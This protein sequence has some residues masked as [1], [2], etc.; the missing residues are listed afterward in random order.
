MSHVFTPLYTL[1]CA[2]DSSSTTSVAFAL[3]DSLLIS[4]DSGGRIHVWSLATR[5]ILR[6]YPPLDDADA[7]NQIRLL[8]DTT[9]A[10]TFAVFY[11]SGAI[12][13][14]DASGVVASLLTRSVS[15][16]RP[17]VLVTA[18]G[19]AVCAVPADSASDVLIV[20]L[21]PRLEYVQTVRVVIPLSA[22]TSPLLLTPR[23]TYSQQG[24]GAESTLLAIPNTSG[25]VSASAVPSESVGAVM[26]TRLLCVSASRLTALLACTESGHIAVITFASADAAPYYRAHRKMSALP[27]LTVDVSA[28]DAHNSAAQIIGVCGGADALIHVFRLLCASDVVSVIALRSVRLASAGVNTVA[29]R[30]DAAVFAVSAWDHTVTLI[31]TA[32]AQPLTV[33]AH[34]AASNESAFALTSAASTTALQVPRSVQVHSL[35]LTAA[36]TSRTAQKLP[37]FDVA[38]LFASADADNCIRVFAFR[39]CE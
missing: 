8:D 37:R 2:A 39:L 32:D 20:Q 1:R 30:A 18:D 16:A 12:A 24:N 27:L 29:L 4:G 9:D 14:Y 3:A 11:K 36:L 15:F 17:H 35:A 19:A 33:T 28:G 34:T 7:V 23:T 10:T 25:D 38:D 21:A 13:V 31:R 5:R 6:S 26:A 22:P